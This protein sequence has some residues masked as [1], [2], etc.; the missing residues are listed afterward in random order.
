VS[1]K[2]RRSSIDLYTQ[3]MLVEIMSIT[4]LLEDYHKQLIQYFLHDGAYNQN[5][6]IDLL[7]SLRDRYE[8]K[9]KHKDEIRTFTDILLPLINKH[10]NQYGIEIKQVA[11]EEH[12]NEIYFVCTQ[13]FKPQFVKMDT[14]YTE[15]EAAIFEKLLELVITNDEKL[16]K[17]VLF[18][19]NLIYILYLDV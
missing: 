4:T 7:N 8:L 18:L 5:E 17:N 1:K 13:N 6:L 10:I 9:I 15:K 12:E 3:K 2:K 16:V 19:F 11:S 14:S